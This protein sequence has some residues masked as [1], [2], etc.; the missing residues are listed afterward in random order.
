MTAPS[1]K[2]Q[3]TVTKGILIAWLLST[4][5]IGG[6]YTLFNH[7]GLFHVITSQK[8]FGI[9]LLIS[10]VSLIAGIAR[11]AQLRHFSQNIDGSTPE[12]GSPLDIT[13][14]YITNTVEQ[15]LLFVLGALGLFYVAPDIAQRLLPIMSVWF[16]IARLLFW[17]GYRMAPLKRAVGFA[18]TFHPTIFLF[19][20]AAYQFIVT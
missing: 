5:F 3:G 13:R 17:V 15:L 4:V 16:L 6:S 18:A 20:L 8:V 2:D 1:R 9:T 12:S 7:L 10:S 11:A 19:G 14:R